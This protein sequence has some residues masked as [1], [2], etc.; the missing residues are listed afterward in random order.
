MKLNTWHRLNPLLFWPYREFV[1]ALV[2]R[3]I[4]SRY[5]QMALGPLWIILQPLVQVV[6]Y[7]FVLGVIAAL[8][9]EG[10]P[11]P[12]FTYAGLLPWIFFTR[13]LTEGTG[14]LVR[15]MSLMTRVYFPRMIIPVSAVLACLIDFCMSLIVV[16]GMV[17]YFGLVPS[18]PILLLPVFLCLSVMLAAV[19][20]LLFAGLQV[21]FRDTKI[22]VGF[23]LQFWL[24]A[25]PVAYSPELVPANLL[26]YYQLNPMYWVVVGFRFC[27]LGTE[28]APSPSMYLSMALIC[29]IA[30]IGGA[31]FHHTEKTAI[32]YL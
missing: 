21:R 12:V 16:I 10:I 9:S 6:V 3:E 1:K 13:A 30:A 19:I 7:S 27:L 11:Y 29:L 20:S 24:Y 25:S 8:P 23:V 31:V 14:S 18:W 28:F 22:I 5:R 32:D 15:N 2:T 4:K 17:L 26:P